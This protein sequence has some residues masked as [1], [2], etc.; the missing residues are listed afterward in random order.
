MEMHF[1]FARF[2]DDEI[3]KTGRA[4]IP[5]HTAYVEISFGRVFS[6]EHFSAVWRV[7]SRLFLDQ[8]VTLIQH[9]GKPQTIASPREY[10]PQDVISLKRFYSDYLLFACGWER[11]ISDALETTFATLETY[12]P[13]TPWASIE[14]YSIPVSALPYAGLAATIFFHSLAVLAYLVT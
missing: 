11:S 4:I 7:G 5:M 14:R 8:Y 6:K 2:D 12:G 9:R 13:D 10:Y 1:T 3:N